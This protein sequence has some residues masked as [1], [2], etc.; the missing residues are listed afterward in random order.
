MEILLQVRWRLYIE[1][2]HWFPIYKVDIS[3]IIWYCILFPNWNWPF[4]ERA[5]FGCL[6]DNFPSVSMF[7]FHTKIIS[8]RGNGHVISPKATQWWLPMTED[9]QIISVHIISS[10][11]S[12]FISPG[13]R[14]YIS[15]ITRCYPLTLG[16]ELRYFRWLTG[17][18][19]VGV[20][21]VACV[22]DTAWNLS[23]E[24]LILGS[25]QTFYNYDI[26][27]DIITENLQQSIQ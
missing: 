13:I 22:W 10:M 17:M 8:R 26:I 3:D 18:Y 9:I 7:S 23:Y 15:D 16:S 24:N 14:L 27:S 4:C 19:G 6:F 21:K 5:Y 1:S 12:D 25:I 11:I 20:I 2:I